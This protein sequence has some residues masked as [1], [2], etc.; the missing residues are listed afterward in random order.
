MKKQKFVLFCAVIIFSISSFAQRLPELAVPENYVLTF[1]PDFFTNTFKGEETLKLNVLKPTTQIVLNSVDIEFNEINISSGGQTQAAKVT[2][3]K[4]KQMVTL[5]VEKEL[6]PGPASLQ[7]KYKGLLNDELRGFYIGRDELG[8]KYAVTQFESTDARR[9]F[10]SFDEPAYKAT[11]D[12]T[13]V[14]DKDLAVISNTKTLTDTPDASAAKHAVHF[15]TTPR[16]SSYLLAIVVGHFESIAGSADGIPIRVW[17]TP[18]KKELGRFALESAE[19]ILPYYDHYFGIK[20]PYG[21]LDLVGLPDFS[22]GAME[23][24][25]CITFREV[26]LMLNSQRASLEA[27]KRVASVVAHEMAHQWFGDLVTM[28]WWDDVWLNEGFAT[29][30]SS[31]PLE[32]W[33]TEWHFEVDDV[34]ESALS[35][36]TD[37]LEN[38]RPIHQE[39]ETPDQIEELFDGIAYGKAAA[40]LRMLETYMGPDKFQAG[41]NAYL[42][43]HS[44]ANATASDF[45]TALTQASNK[46]IDKI[47]PT[48]VQQ[49]GVPLVTVEA[50]C[51]G[52]ADKV[53]LEQQRYFY[54]RS[55]FT[56]KNQDELWMIPVCLKT[57]ESNN[58]D[59]KC[60]LLSEKEQR[61]SLKGCSPWVF[62]NRGAYGY[63]R[64]GYTP[65][66]LRAISKDME[67]RLTP[68][69][70]VLLLGDAWSSLQ[71]GRITISDYLAFAE[72]FQHEHDSMVIQQFAIPLEYLADKVV[73]DKDREAFRGWIRHLFAQTAQE[74]GWDAKPG[75]SDNQM[76]LRAQLMHVLGATARDPQVLA[77]AKEL[78]IAALTQPGSVSSEMMTPALEVAAVNGDQALYDKVMARW[79]QSPDPEQRSLYSQT[80]V[81][82]T[83]PKLVERTLNFLISSD[84]RSQD[85][86][87]LLARE[88]RNHDAQ[89][90]V[91][92]FV[93]QHWQDIQNVGGAF[94]NGRLVAASAAFCSVDMRDSEVSFFATHKTSSPRTQKQSLE[95]M[96]YCIDLKSQQRS[97]LTSWLEQHHES[98]GE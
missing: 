55:M 19:H 9:A 72:G 58:A 6:A 57:G 47:M 83:D 43:K 13:V 2:E 28:Q 90:Q 84:V 24:T 85:V 59:A 20:Y 93:Q 51:T 98:A 37:S 54:N 8:N 60:E 86:T 14:A 35:L 71:V 73:E 31:K 96:N 15:A 22:A 92:D 78:A 46:P 48:F 38:T 1:T 88:L 45:W 7:I 30:M 77:K 62:A 82:F 91:W 27:K 26:D 40:V 36:N 74:V 4:E 21:K 56:A 66:A 49:A 18:G 87:L 16:M 81:R 95:R 68:A 29:W 61:T 44:Y 42:K 63:Y 50:K 76:L 11:F 75:E 25:A 39:A 32:A 41:V 53:D 89:K 65:E 80:L 69:E 17:T 79:K 34:V 10:P 70:R 3:D 52:G 23:N 33:H 5:Q 12:V 97:A 67:A 94:S 64:S